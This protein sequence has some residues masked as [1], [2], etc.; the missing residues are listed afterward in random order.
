MWPDIERAYVTILR[1]TVGVRVATD[2]PGDVE[3]IPG[4]FIRVTRGPGS[5]DGITDQPLLDVETFHPER[6]EAERLAER[7]RQAI[8]ASPNR[9]G[10]L[11]D[12]AVTASTP[13]RVFYSPNVERYV[14]SYRLRLRRPRA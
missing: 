7:A 13:A 2:I 4:G 6:H 14:A 3:T 10:T 11:I 5:D 8:L 9:A 1:E 12:A